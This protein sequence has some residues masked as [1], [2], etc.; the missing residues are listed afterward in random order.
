MLFNLSRYAMADSQSWNWVAGIK[1]SGVSLSMLEIEDFLKYSKINQL[2]FWSIGKFLVIKI[3]MDNFTD[4]WTKN[5]Y[6]LVVKLIRGFGT[7]Q[8]G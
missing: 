8:T 4:S 1:Y 7:I 5:L 3:Q 2:L 6:L